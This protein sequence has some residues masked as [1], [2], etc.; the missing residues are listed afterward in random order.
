VH[1]RRRR[2]DDDDDSLE[3]RVGP[4]RPGCGRHRPCRAGERHRVCSSARLTNAATRPDPAAE[5]EAGGAEAGA[6]AREAR[7]VS[8]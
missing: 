3:A 1:S 2:P 7:R 4:G 5:T 6:V 8:H